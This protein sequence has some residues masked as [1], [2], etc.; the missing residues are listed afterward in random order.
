MAKLRG[1]ISNVPLEMTEEEV[2]KEIRG[3]KVMDVKRLQT[4]KGG[5]K[6]GS[7]SMLVQFESTLPKEVKMGSINYRVREYI[8]NPI[9][10][11]KCQRIG[12]VAQQCR[13]KNKDV[14][15]VEVTMIM[16]NVR[17]ALNSNAVTVEENTVLHMEAVLSRLKQKRYRNAK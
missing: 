4:N 2:K 5:V 3:G 13:G 9:R 8:P 12:H 10:C 11:Y 17:R 6:K 14:R 16:V 7:L 1:V 15:N